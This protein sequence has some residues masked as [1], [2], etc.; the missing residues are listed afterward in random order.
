MLIS[1][2]E[3][4]NVVVLFLGAFAKLQ[5]ATISLVM[6]VCLYAWNNSAATGWILMKS[7]VW[8]FFYLKPVHKIQM[9]LQSNQSNAYCT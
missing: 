3:R 1:S 4:K 5:K 8:T 2:I 7:E 6:S 9:S